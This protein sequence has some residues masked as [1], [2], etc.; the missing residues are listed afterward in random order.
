MPRKLKTNEDLVRDLMTRSPQGALCQAFVVQ[1]LQTYCKQVIEAGPAAF[2][3][4]M[5]SGQAWVGIAKDID[6]RIEEFYKS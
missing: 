3:S 2:D 6:R 4:A 5:L 1:A